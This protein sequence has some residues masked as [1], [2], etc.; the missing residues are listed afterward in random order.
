MVVIA[1]I[2]NMGMDIASKCLAESDQKIEHQGRGKS[3]E[4]SF[5]QA[6]FKNTIGPAAKVDGHFGQRFIH[7]HKKI[8]GASDARF[9]SQSLAESLTQNQ[10]A[11]FDQVV[12]FNTQI[13]AGLQ[14][15]IEQTMAG[16]GFEH[17]AEKI[18]LAIDLTLAAAINIEYQGYLRFPGITLA[19]CLS[20]PVPP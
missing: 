15:K 3:A 7:G 14:F 19:N 5:P 4:T 8:T 6:A 9:I 2:T 11:V 20:H 17:V 10:A 16:K 1:A 18:N 13:A 12:R